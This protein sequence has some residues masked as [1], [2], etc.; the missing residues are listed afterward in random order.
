MPTRRI[1]LAHAKRGVN[2]NRVSERIDALVAQ[3]GIPTAFPTEVR[4][5]AQQARSTWKE[6]AG[7]H[8][9]LT[10]IDFVT[11]DP[12]GSMDLDQAMF[13][14]KKAD[15]YR[16]LYAI[17]DVPL[18]VTTGGSLDHE[19][20]ER[21][22]TV[23]LPDRR[24]PLHPEQLSEGA[25][26]LLPGQEAPAFV[27]DFDLD[28]EA[29]VRHVDLERAI[30]KNREQLDYDTVQKELDAGTAHPL[31]VLLQEVGD[32]R[33]LLEI[34]RG[35]ASLG[36]PEQEVEVEGERVRLV[37]RRQ[38]PIEQANAHISLMTGMA[39]ADIMIKG[40][41]GVL[42]TMPPAS[43]EAIATF[44]RQA[45]ALREPW[46]EDMEYGAFLRTL[47]WSNGRH[48]ALLNYATKLFRGAGYESFTGG[49]LPENTEQS[50]LAAPYAHTTAPLRRLVDRF[51]LHICHALTKGEQVDPR[52]LDALPE[53]PSYMGSA[54][55][56]N[57]GLERA[58][59]DIVESEVLAQLEGR[60]LIGTIVDR[61]EPSNGHGN[62]N[63]ESNGKN[64]ANGHGNPSARIN[65]QFA[66]PPIAQWIDV[67][68]HDPAFDVGVKI[69]AT[70]E[71]V[72]KE[73]TT[74]SFTN[75]TRVGTTASAGL[76]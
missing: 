38:H 29:R 62:G 49:K 15:G 8:A 70:V 65:V 17:A 59:K 4:E 64:H 11:L 40:G 37:W 44:R 72:N 67:D 39:A 27:W 12:E 58:A 30:V 2:L 26:S 41:T 57:A 54:N 56:R 5:E 47:D 10:D 33:G 76:T 14:E 45:A 1:S 68:P 19:S 66:E 69:S 60:A 50:A 28:D 36:S 23:Y 31:M 34:E 24:I 3:A 43:K 6:R 35:G 32:K 46:P 22:M 7:T 52:I 16:V 18:F 51:S 71:S 13:I 74:A 75:V 55:S 20:R 61:R 53:V 21:G 48:L 9:D 63:G 25:A 73:K 42:R